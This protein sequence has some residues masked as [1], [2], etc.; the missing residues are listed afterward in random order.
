MAR[1]SSG[2]LRVAVLG[3]GIMG[4][5]LALMLAG[6]GAKVTLYDQADVPFS[7]ASR[8]NEGKIHLGYLYSADPSLRTAQKIAPGSLHFVPL[9]EE[10]LGTS[11]RDVMTQTDDIFLTHRK[12][13]VPPDAMEDYFGKV[14]DLLKST[15]DAGL[16]PANLAG[17]A[18]RLSRTE[19]LSHT[20]S[21]DIV[22]GFSIPE[23]SIMTNAVADGFVAALAAEPRVELR[24]G[25]RITHVEEHD[26]RLAVRG[27]I[28]GNLQAGETYDIVIN[29]LWEGRREID[30]SVQPD[31]DEVW[32]NRYRFALFVRVREPQNLS[33]AMIATGPFG[34]VKNYNGRDFYLSW[35][36][37]GLAENSDAPDVPPPPRLDAG[38]KA[39]LASQVLDSLGTFLPAIGDLRTS[40]ETISVEGGWVVAPG[41]GDLG[42]RA[43]ALHRRDRFGVWRR[44]NYISV[45]TGKY[46]TAP[47]M[48]DR[49]VRE[50]TQ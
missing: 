2:D 34:D 18:R 35:Y 10:L 19:L 36:P 6:K 44:G 31:T 25:F 30:R 49:I 33:S 40:I 32:S 16:Y 47:W 48:A 41:G 15:P 26:G 7:K 46:S 11:V 50:I 28:G 23:R 39:K 42:D 17:G 37:A 24:L 3:S 20:D 9:V 1:A 38:Q 14:T 22:A 29:A 5:S 45:D 4:S 12:S 8:W 27:A 21:S 43:S 13:V